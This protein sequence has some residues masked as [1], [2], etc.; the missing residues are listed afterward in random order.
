[1]SHC[2]AR[3]ARRRHLHML[4]HIFIVAVALG[5]TW[6]Q[7]QETCDDGLY[8]TCQSNLN[9]ALNINI[10]QPWHEP[11]RYRDAVEAFTGS[12]FNGT[13]NVCK[14]FREFKTC[15]G[16]TTMLVLLRRILFLPAPV[17]MRDTFLRRFSTRCTTIAGAGLQIA[18]LN[19]KCFQDT[20]TNYG[21][22]I[23]ACRQAWESHVRVN[24]DDAC[25]QGN[26]LLKC[27]EDYFGMQCGK[28]NQAALFWSCEY[29]RVQMFTR[30]PQCSLSCSMPIVGGI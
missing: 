25:F 14:A 9:T 23:R 29:A 27:N 3:R 2:P 5:G 16:S 18:A 1:M 15:L 20:W 7:R 12:G 30:F 28:Q 24:P 6:A 19:D 10:N 26:N 22:S 8:A 11:S 13:R 17:L 21:S 4:S